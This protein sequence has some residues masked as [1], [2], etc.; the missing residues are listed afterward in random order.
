M[1]QFNQQEKSFSS[2][3]L[4]PLHSISVAGFLTKISTWKVNCHITH[5]YI[6][7]SR[8]SGSSGHEDCGSH[9]GKRYRHAK[10][11]RA[12]R[13]AAPP[14]PGAAPHQP[15]AATERHPGPAAC[16]AGRCPLPAPA[17]CSARGTLRLQRLHHGAGPAL[18]SLVWQKIR[19]ARAGAWTCMCPHALSPL[20]ALEARR[21]GKD[22]GSF[23]GRL[24]RIVGFRSDGSSALHSRLATWRRRQHPESFGED[25]RE[26]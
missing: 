16:G 13:G 18:T 21:R 20:L 23:K 26:R 17:A 11:A 2:C 15:A 8:T 4:F 22:V 25:I 10:P 12:V 1:F 6:Y 3:Y 5:T 19:Y 7:I 9:P 24:S 14:R